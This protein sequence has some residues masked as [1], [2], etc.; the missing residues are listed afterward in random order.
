MP[1]AAGDAVLEV[2][3]GLSLLGRAASMLLRRPRLFWLGAVPPLVTSVVFVVL[4]VLLLAELP[5]LTTALTPFAAGWSPGLAL[6]TRVIV[7]V[8]LVGGAA[9]LMV[10]VFTTLTLALGS[11]VYDAISEAVDEAFPGAPRAPEEPL[12]STLTR[13]VRQSVGLVAVSAFGRPRV[14]R[15]RLRPRRRAGRGRG[16]WGAVRWLDAGRRA[17]RQPARAARRPH[18]PGPAR[19]ARPAAL[20]QPGAGRPVLPAAVRA[21]RRGRRVPRRDGRR[22]AARPAAGRRTDRATRGPSGPRPTSYH[23]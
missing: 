11:P 22:H 16:R 6:T 17:G 18:A 19:R 9:L 5:A 20:A 14:L 8:L 15:R 1:S 2:G 13:T 7:G 10:L 23:R 12:R 3:G 4:I 21:L